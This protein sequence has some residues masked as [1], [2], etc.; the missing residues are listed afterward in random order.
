MSQHRADVGLAHGGCWAGLVSAGHR[1]QHPIKATSTGYS[2]Q[3]TA[4][5]RPMSASGPI[6]PSDRLGCSPRF[7]ARPDVAFGKKAKVF[8]DRAVIAV[9]KMLHVDALLHPNQKLIS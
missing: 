2:W 9:T 7:L 5:L 8:R 6:D 1:V 4:D 3:K